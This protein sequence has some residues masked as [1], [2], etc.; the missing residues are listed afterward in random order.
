MLQII[1]GS[2]NQ[3]AICLNLTINQFIDTVRCYF[4][5]LDFKYINY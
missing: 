2:C 5:L 4:F 3:S 1:C